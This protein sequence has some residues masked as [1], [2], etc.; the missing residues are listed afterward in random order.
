[1]A[2]HWWCTD[3]TTIGYV[4]PAADGGACLDDM[5]N[6]LLSKNPRRALMKEV[7][8]VSSNA[9]CAAFV[10]P[11]G[12]TSVA[13]LPGMTEEET[14]TQETTPL[15]DS[16]DWVLV[17]DDAELCSNN[18]AATHFVLSNGLC[19]T[20]LTNADLT[21]MESVSEVPKGAIF[22]AFR[23]AADSSSATEV[24]WEPLTRF[25]KLSK[26]LREPCRRGTK[27]HEH[28]EHLRQGDPLIN[29]CNWLDMRELY[30][31]MKATRAYKAHQYGLTMRA[32]CVHKKH[33]ATRHLLG[34]STGPSASIDITGARDTRAT[35]SSS[36]SV[37][38]MDP[39]G[40]VLDEGANTPED[41][42]S[43][44][45]ED[46]LGEQQSPVGIES[47]LSRSGFEKATRKFN[48]GGKLEKAQVDWRVKAAGLN[49]AKGIHTKHGIAAGMKPRSV[50]FGGSRVIE[51]DLS[52]ITYG[53]NGADV[54]S[55]Y[56]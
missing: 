40:E 6:A 19:S 43:A 17:T 30:E 56:C 39:I 44:S 4:E 28:L 8:L 1:M 9:R 3:W 5:K 27:S 53:I 35:R 38:V 32:L 54:A 25:R 24:S 7:L 41:G 13:S 50:D 46:D 16:T 33:L 22:K 20:P 15:S 10:L 12:I 26:T 2:A 11:S 18:K 34:P 23:S 51:D 42:A 31:S 55:Q 45:E 49:T 48:Q 21:W 47:S 52:R 37:M 29:L 14:A 36:D